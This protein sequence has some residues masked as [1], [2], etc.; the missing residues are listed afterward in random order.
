MR[1]YV[2]NSSGNG[3]MASDNKP[4][5]KWMLAKI[6]MAYFVSWCAMSCISTGQTW[7][8][9]WTLSSHIYDYSWLKDD[10]GK[11]L[12]NQ[13]LADVTLI[14]Q[15]ILSVI[16]MIDTLHT[17][18]GVVPTLMP[19]DF[20]DD[21]SISNQVMAACRLATSHYLTEC[22]HSTMLPYGLQGQD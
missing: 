9:L 21:K 22:W 12:I 6:I 18:N 14:I 19:Q 20:I 16:F 13:P 11:Y 2:I 5:P 15:L 10:A 8:S 3:S 17:C 7:D 4:L 1:Q